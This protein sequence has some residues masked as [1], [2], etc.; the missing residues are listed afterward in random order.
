MIFGGESRD[1][2]QVTE[3][4]RRYL[5]KMKEEG[6]SDE[7]FAVAKKAVY[8]D[9]VSSL[10]SVGNIANT[11]A[12]YYFNG[13]ELFAYIDAVAAAEKEAVDARLRKMLDVN[14]CTLSVVK[15]GEA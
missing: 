12:D 14:N 15:N 4:I 5:V 8:G 9:I 1:P 13:N 10:N 11:I 7:D 2:Q 3:T 6:L